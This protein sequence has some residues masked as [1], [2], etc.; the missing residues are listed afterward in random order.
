VEI[1][2]DAITLDVLPKLARQFDEPLIDSSMIPTHLVSRVVRSQCTVALGG[3]G[4]DELF[5]GY[6]HYDRLL[7]LEKRFGWVPRPVRAPIARRV[8]SALPLGFKG[9]NWLQAL[10]TDLDNGVPMVASYFDRARRRTLM[11]RYAT[12]P[13]V[14][15]SAW[16]QGAR[17]PGDLL[18]RATRV[19]FARYLPE[20]ILV[21][22]DRASML[23]SLEVRA[24]MLGRRVIE[25]AFGRVPSKL[26]ATAARRKLLLKRLASRILPPEFDQARKQGFAVPLAEW[27]K[28]GPWRKYFE[29]VL[30]GPEQTTFDRGVVRALFAG[31]DRG[32]NNSERLFGLLMFELWRREYGIAIGE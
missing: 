25:F 31:H 8:S 24:P 22:V 27:L 2:A 16:E 26:K 3:D 5:G 9:R 14:A 17:V 15:E 1:E 19:D 29:D 13:L 20:D 10:A 12:W 7:L 21:K 6:S 4:G 11:S 28:S 30:L 32:S 18:Q 23:S